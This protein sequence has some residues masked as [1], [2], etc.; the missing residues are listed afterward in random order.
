MGEAKFQNR[1]IKKGLKK[2]GVLLPFLLA[3]FL[4]ISSNSS[5]ALK[6]ATNYVADTSTVKSPSVILGQGNNG[7]S[8]ISTTDDYATVTTTAGFTFYENASATSQGV[9]NPT[10][11]HLAGGQS[12]SGTVS[13]LAAVDGHY[14]T[15]Y[16][17]SGL[18]GFDFYFNF[19]GVPSSNSFNFAMYEYYHGAVGHQIRI[20][21]YNFI[22]NT[23]ILYGMYSDETAFTWHNV[24]ITN[25]DGLI[26][27]GVVRGRLNHP[28]PGN[29]LHFD[30]IDYIALGVTN[31]AVNTDFSIPASNG[32]FP[33]AAGASAYL[34]SPAFLSAT[35][36]YPGAYLLDLWASATSSGTMGVNFIVVDSSN[37]VVSTVASGNTE[38]IGIV[39]S[40][41][42]TTFVGAQVT[43]PAGGCLIANITNPTGSG[44]TFTIYW[45]A[46]QPTNYQTPADY[47]YVVSIANLA[48]AATYISASVY[49]TSAISR[50]T[51]V[52]ITIY[53]PST[54]QVIITNGVVTQSSGPTMTLPAASTLYVKVHAEANAFG[55]SNIVMLMK[56]SP[57]SKPF[58]DDVIN[59]TVN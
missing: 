50:L 20:Q 33:V 9:L 23:W 41:V 56:F 30:E 15:I 46:G 39:K 37:N 14:V 32:N 29:H 40:E 10:S 42:K 44:K 21:F 45:G 8:L 58:T 13:D 17:S 28:S 24:T 1:K 54:N 5:V 2:L 49:S 27:N 57:S 6:M 36:L 19:T 22:S 31:V 3:L 11:M 52:T 26:Q 25:T 4:I 43:V 7:T 18:P 38:T 12:I 55:S 35:T 34:Q 47:D 51:N 48:S 53:A 16:E 59:L